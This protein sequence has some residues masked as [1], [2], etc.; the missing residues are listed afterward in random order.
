MPT[1]T[2]KL[3]FGG[4][5]H[6]PHSKRLTENMPILPGPVPKTLSIPLSQHIGAPAKAVVEKRQE[7]TVG[8]VIAEAGGFVS[9]PVHSPV[10]GT[11]KDI[12]LVSHTVLG[13]TPAVII[14]VDEENN[15]AKRPVYKQF[16]EKVSI[17]NFSVE[18]ILDAIAQA[19]I[20]G[21]GGAGFPTRVKIEPKS[22]PKKHTMIAIR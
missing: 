4:G 1:A 21:M 15:E 18:Q 8:Q 7:V 2:K 13:R 11:V 22:D 3:T 6:P 16:D 19:G 10:N 5:V 9:A 17:D 14:N 12:A 20:V